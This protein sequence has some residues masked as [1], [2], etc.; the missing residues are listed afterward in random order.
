MS[1]GARLCFAGAIL[2]ALT[3]CD[4][5]ATP[6]RTQVLKDAETKAAENDFPRAISLYEAALDGT[7]KSADVHYRLAIIYDD[8]M[9]DQVSALHHFKRYLALAPAGP[10]VAE[11]K[12]YMKRDELALLTNLSGDAVVSRAEAVRLK[13]ENLD[14]RK[15]IEDRWAHAKTLPTATDKALPRD[16]KA[17][18]S[19][20]RSSSP[21]NGRRHVV[22]PGDTLASISRRYYKTSARW[23]D[24]LN[25]NSSDLDGAEKLRVGQTL[26]IP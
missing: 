14:L 18:K 3:A 19:A 4:R 2:S 1:G 24:I 11:V 26:V 13:N 15:Q 12:N 16:P 23:K 25:A 10:K 9:S 8:K 20:A 5:L 7:A 21:P 6:P 22:Q 17:D